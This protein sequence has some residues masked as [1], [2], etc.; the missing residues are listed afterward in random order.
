VVAVGRVVAPLWISPLGADNLWIA[1]FI[2]L[3]LT[4]LYCAVIMCVD[5]SGGKD[6]QRAAQA[7]EAAEA[8]VFEIL[9][10]CVHVYMSRSI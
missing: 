5:L 1:F 7:A 6:A 9:K 8:R 4:T 3:P 2:P 10:P